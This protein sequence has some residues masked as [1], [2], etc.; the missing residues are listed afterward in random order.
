MSAGSLKY[1]RWSIDTKP[2]WD[3]CLRGELLYQICGQCGEIVF[4]PR[5]ACPYCLHPE[6]NWCR[7]T[8][9]GEIYSFTVQHL[10]VDRSNPGKLPLALGIIRLDEGFYMFAEVDE[11][12]LQVL[13]IGARVSVY[14][15]QVALDLAL[16]KFR[17]HPGA[18]AQ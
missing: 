12:N 4:H 7:S 5:A 11:T 14:F 15:D 17:I 2:Y 18:A 13:K 3:G 1:P 16:P 6:L 10:P 9:E 8:G